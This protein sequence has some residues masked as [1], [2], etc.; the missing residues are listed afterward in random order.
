MML[1]PSLITL[2]VKE[3]VG[4]STIN[5]S[6]NLMIKTIKE[7]ITAEEYE[8]ITGEKYEC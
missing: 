7:K 3:G 5:Y 2:A 1:D 8:E 6:P 4:Y